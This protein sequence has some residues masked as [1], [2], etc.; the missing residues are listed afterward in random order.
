MVS[1]LAFR[2]PHCV[3]AS[4]VKGILRTA[5]TSHFTR[6]RLRPGDPGVLTP[7]VLPSI[8]HLASTRHPRKKGKEDHLPWRGGWPRLDRGRQE[9]RLYGAGGLAGEALQAQE[10]QLLFCARPWNAELLYPLTAIKPLSTTYSCAYRDIG[11]V[12]EDDGGNAIVLLKDPLD[13]PVE[14]F[15]K[16]ME[17]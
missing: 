7:K 1:L 2:Q 8:G 4:S 6:L 16:E 12:Y 14:R 11:S 17:S 5:H 3:A 13:T 15:V 10:D 9:R